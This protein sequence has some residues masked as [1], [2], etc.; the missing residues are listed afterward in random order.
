VLLFLSCVHPIPPPPPPAVLVAPSMPSLAFR[1]R[2]KE[3]V[4]TWVW[5]DEVA[6]ESLPVVWEDRSS[7]CWIPAGQG[8]GWTRLLDCAAPVSEQGAWGL[9][10][11]SEAVALGMAAR[12]ASTQLGPVNSAWRAP[13]GMLRHEQALSRLRC[14][15]QIWSLP[16]GAA[17]AAFDEP[18]G[19]L[20]LIVDVGAQLCLVSLTDEAE[21]QVCAP[22]PAHSG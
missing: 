16:K 21:V 7:M 20:W 22:D 14:G 13:C 10:G 18:R 12:R 5:L 3:A 19:G 2:S 8:A 4:H 1:V 9:V 11:L 17:Q 6:L 15:D